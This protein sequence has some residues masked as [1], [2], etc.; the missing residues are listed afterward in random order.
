MLVLVLQYCQDIRYQLTEFTV[1]PLIHGHFETTFDPT[2]EANFISIESN[3]WGYQLCIV[4]QNFLTGGVT[5]LKKSPV[6]GD[7]HKL[8]QIWHTYGVSESIPA[9]AAGGHL[10]S[11]PVKR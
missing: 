5:L 10:D 6:L 1:E 4:S 7:L 8:L 3:L 2:C 9:Q 11:E